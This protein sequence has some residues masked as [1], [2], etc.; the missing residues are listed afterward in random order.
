[1]SKIKYVFLM[2]LFIISIS[3]IVCG[4]YVI[5]YINVCANID[6]DRNPPKIE[7]INIQNTNVGY[8][9]YANKTHTITARIKIIEKNIKENHIEEDNLIV[10]IGN[11]QITPEKL[12]IKRIEQTSDEIIYDIILQ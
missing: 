9:S 10:K 1:M 4:K 5:E 7:L 11:I 2:I 3:T 12:I 8:E 6:I